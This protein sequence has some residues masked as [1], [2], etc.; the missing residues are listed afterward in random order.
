MRTSVICYKIGGGL[1]RERWKHSRE[2]RDAHTGKNEI[3]FAQ[4]F[5]H[6]KEDVE[7]DSHRRQ[8]RTR[9]LHILQG[10]VARESLG[11]FVEREYYWS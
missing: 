2:V 3:S 7:Q 10:I 8:K 1:N 4:R 6:K 9:G 5:L 11:I